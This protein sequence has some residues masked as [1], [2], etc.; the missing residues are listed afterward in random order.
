M[1]KPDSRPSSRPNRSVALAR[2][3][4]AAL[5]LALGSA[6]DPA[7]KATATGG[8]AAAVPGKLSREH[9]SCASSS[10]CEGEL[11]CFEGRCASVGGSVTAEY[12]EALGDAREVGEPR[13]AADNYR[14]ALAA[15]EADEVEPPAR[16]R[17]KLGAQ[18]ARLRDDRAVA[19]EAA[20]TLHRCLLASPVGSAQRHAA[21]ASLA[22]L[23]ASGLDPRH[24]AAAE[25]A[26]G[27]LTRRAAAPS[28]Q[29]MTVKVST[30][31]R[32]RSRS[33]SGFIE[34]LEGPGVKAALAPCWTAHV[35]ATG[36]RAL[37]V[38]LP[39]AHGYRL[40]EYDDFERAVL[41]VREPTSGNPAQ[42]QA[43]AC[44]RGALAP[45]ADDYA[46]RTASESR[47]QVIATFELGP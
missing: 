30:D 35:S 2:V 32:P 46:R 1:M 5:V 3:R 38:A 15:Y 10:N 33:F 22:L 27:Y 8:P 29:A 36:E 4:T 45:I 37:N 13:G 39:L 25:A 24:L 43:G 18:L 9:E 19:E 28:A 14:A 44:I 31:T 20:A 17:C 11:R 6:C 34:V 16:L 41:E 40:D 42:I 21:L 47:W 26:Q 23:D 7:A 12:L